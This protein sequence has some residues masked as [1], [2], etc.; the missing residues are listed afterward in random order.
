MLLLNGANTAATGSLIPQQLCLGNESNERLRVDAAPAQINLF[1]NVGH[2]AV[3]LDNLALHVVA[4]LLLL[5]LLR[6]MVRPLAMEDA[7][8]AD[9]DPPVKQQ[10]GPAPPMMRTVYPAPMAACPHA[11]YYYYCRGTVI[12]TA[13]AGVVSGCC[14]GGSMS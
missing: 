13:A 1:G 6:P 14:I 8:A 9:P 7:T 11:H 10:H 4:L 3:F 12:V 5:V 2:V